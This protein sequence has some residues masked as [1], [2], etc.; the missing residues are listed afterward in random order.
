VSILDDRG[1]LDGL[2]SLSEDEL[3]VARVGHVG[4]DLSLK[5]AKDTNEKKSGE[6][7]RP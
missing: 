7:T 3:D 1:L 4:V 2:L 5:L 6:H